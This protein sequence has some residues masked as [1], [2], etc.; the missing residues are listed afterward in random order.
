M[1][2]I[3]QILDGDYLNSLKSEKIET[4]EHEN[5]DIRDKLASDET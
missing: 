2:D 5:M 1:P 4:S 3:D